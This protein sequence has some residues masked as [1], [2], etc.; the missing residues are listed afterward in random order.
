MSELARTST[1]GEWSAGAGLGRAAIALLIRGV[2]VVPLWAGL[3][4]VATPVVNM[5]PWSIATMAIIGLLCAIPGVAIGHA[6]SRKLDEVA[7]CQSV[8]LTGMAILVALGVIVIGLEVA[9]I[10]R[11]MPL[12]SGYVSTATTAFAAIWTVRN[13][14]FAD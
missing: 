13:L 1:G 12:W 9:T 2:I 14:H 7:G 3:T 8:L 6:L 11:P 5:F 10:F 4:W